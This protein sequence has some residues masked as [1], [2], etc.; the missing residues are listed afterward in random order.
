MLLLGAVGEVE[1]EDVS[2]GPEHPLP[3]RVRIGLADAIVITF[4]ALEA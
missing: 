4:E 3:A 1:A 2:P